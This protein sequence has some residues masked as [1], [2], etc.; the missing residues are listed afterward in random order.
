MPDSEFN[1]P[2]SCDDHQQGFAGIGSHC[3]AAQAHCLKKARDCRAFEPLGLTW[4][5]YVERRFG[6][7]RA[8]ADQ[9]IRHLDQF[10]ENY[11]HISQ[12]ARIGPATYRRLVNR[13]IDGRLH[14]DAKQLEIAPENVPKIQAVIESIRA[15]WRQA[16]PG[17]PDPAPCAAPA[18][19]DFDPVALPD[20]DPV[21]DADPA[22]DDPAA[23]LDDWHQAASV[24]DEDRFFSHFTADARLFGVCPC[25][26]WTLSRFRVW[27][28]PRFEDPAAWT[29][30]PLDRSI[31]FSADRQVAW[32]D[33][34]LRL[35]SHEPNFGSGV[36]VREDGTWK[37]A[38]YH[39]AAPILDPYLP[40]NVQFG[41]S[42]RVR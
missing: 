26:R 38:R 39:F 16:Q 10:G 19:P 40:E 27:A 42:S 23:V 17:R 7:S 1:D 32:F 18:V 29:Y 13:V 5:E 15:E 36:L 3:S 21:P 33:E 34:L 35:P 11:F 20:A 24:S 12:F 28:E 22:P 37:I 8:K 30:T 25:E 4:D 14:F 2:E 41:T 9:L 6:I 31:T